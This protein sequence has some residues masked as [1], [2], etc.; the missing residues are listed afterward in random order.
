MNLFEREKVTA[1]VVMIDTSEIYPNHA[2]PRKDFDP[3]ELIS[4]AQSIKENGILQP[5]TIRRKETKSYELIAGERRL[6][7]SKIAGLREVPCIIVDATAQ[8]SAILAILENIQREDLNYFEEAEGISK[9]IDEWGVTQE[10]AAKKLGKSQSTIANK[11]RI[12]RL[13]NEEKEMLL[14][15]N[16]TER[17]ARALIRI[18]DKKK[19]TNAIKLIT[20]RKLN[21]M[22]TEKYIDELIQGKVIKHPL[23]RLTIVK[24]ERLLY[25]TFKK[26]VDIMKKSGIDAKTQRNEN[27]EYIEYVIKIPKNPKQ[28]HSRPA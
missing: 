3:N 15:A 6:R 25:N 20:I 2:Q 28:E 24:D 23:K 17:H 27:D 16:L 4:L 21:A 10:E 18:E 5:L 22:E 8:K 7:A 14:A 1:K 12:L 19:R 26:V 11:L 13:S 9:L